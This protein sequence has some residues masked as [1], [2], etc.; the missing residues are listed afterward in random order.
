MPKKRSVPTRKS[1][2][3]AH[4]SVSKNLLQEAQEDYEDGGSLGQGSFDQSNP[5]L[6]CTELFAPNAANQIQQQNVGNIE[7]SAS[8]Q[9]KMPH[10]GGGVSNSKTPRLVP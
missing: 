4:L 9:P 3:Q 6:K 8:N 2:S 7:N 1:E 10:T 5:S